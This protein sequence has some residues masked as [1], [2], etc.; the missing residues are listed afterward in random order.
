M[1][2]NQQV[3]AIT[4][5]LNTLRASRQL[6]YAEF[7][8]E[9]DRSLQELLARNPAGVYLSSFRD[10]SL[11]LAAERLAKA[12]EVLRSSVSGVFRLAEVLAK[13]S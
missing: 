13:A 7:Q 2:S 11:W 3:A 8:G 6:T 5:D 12:G 4:R 10:T 9:A 1:N